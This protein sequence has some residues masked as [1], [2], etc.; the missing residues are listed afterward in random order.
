VHVTF[1]GRE[2]SPEARIKEGEKAPGRIQV[3]GENGPETLEVQL[4]A[5]VEFYF[6]SG[7]LAE[8]M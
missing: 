8:A 7:E 4:E 1:Q 2:N 3:A 6:E 5:G